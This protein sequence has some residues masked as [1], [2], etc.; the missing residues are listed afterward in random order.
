FLLLAS[1]FLLLEAVSSVRFILRH[2]FALRYAFAPQLF[3][4]LALI[5]ASSFLL[6]ERALLHFSLICAII[7]LLYQTNR[8]LSLFSTKGR[9][10][11]PLPEMSPPALI[12]CLARLLRQVS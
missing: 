1:S 3:L 2:S 11:A 6:P 7:L 10:H 5:L 9:H 12:R 8:P 4:L